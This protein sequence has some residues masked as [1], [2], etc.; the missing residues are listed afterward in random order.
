MIPYNQINIDDTFSNPMHR[1][2]GK[3]SGLKFCVIEKNNTEKM[4]KM[5]SINC[6]N[7]L[8]GSTF[9]KQNTDRIFSGSWRI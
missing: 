4:I 2:Y 6:S 3:F 5:Q 1:G 9:W 7:E 8:F